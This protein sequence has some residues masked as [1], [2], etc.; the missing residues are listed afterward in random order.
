MATTF[1]KAKQTQKTKKKWY[2]IH[3]EKYSYYVW[4]LPLVPF[5]WVADKIHDYTYSRLLWSENQATKVLDKVLPNVVEWVEEDD[6]Y[7]YCMQW[8]TRSLWA[9]A[10]RHLRKWAR[11]HEYRLRNYIAEGYENA[12]YIKTIEKDYD[13]VWVKFLVK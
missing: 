1:D 6:A 8:G 9:T 11:K 12:N 3:G 13:D 5:V 4:A 7:Y 10:P 2:V